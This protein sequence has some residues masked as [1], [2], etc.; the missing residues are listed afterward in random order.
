MDESSALHI[1]RRNI[2]KRRKDIGAL[3]FARLIQFLYQAN[4]RNC[5]AVAMK[6]GCSG[7]TIQLWV[8][9]SEAFSREPRIG[10]QV[11]KGLISPVPMYR[12][13]SHF[14]D[15]EKSADFAASVVGLGDEAI[16]LIL[17][18]LKQPGR[19]TLDGCRKKVAV[20]LANRI[21]SPAEV[22]LTAQ[23]YRRIESIA[24]KN[25]SNVPS[26]AKRIIEDWFTHNVIGIRKSGSNAMGNVR[27]IKG[28]WVLTLPLSHDMG[29]AIKT[30]ARIVG[31]PL[32]EILN[33]ALR[34]KAN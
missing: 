28:K 3:E 9:L 22:S 19:M 5:N 1:L 16:Q 27:Q 15:F 26:A 24:A 4:N 29:S 23:E 33:E 11:E 13:V 10:E 2:R 6:S 17:K 14:D 34:D 30:Y 12:I 31:R 7:S 8:K 25:R 18:C 21:L 20:I 32:T